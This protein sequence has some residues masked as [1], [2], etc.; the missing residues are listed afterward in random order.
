MEEIVKL[1]RI[2]PNN[3]QKKLAMHKDPQ[4]NLTIIEFLIALN[5]PL[6]IILYCLNSYLQKNIKLENESKQKYV[7]DPK[8]NEY[9]TPYETGVMEAKIIH[10]IYSYIQLNHFHNNNS[11]LNEISESWAEM[12]NILNTL[13][14]DTKIIYT[15]CWIYELL[16]L[17]L[18]KLDLNEVSDYTVKNNITEIFNTITDKLIDCAFNNKTDSINVKEG[19]L[20]L[21]YLP[22]IYLNIIET[23]FSD[24]VHYLYKISFISGQNIDEEIFSEIKN[25]SFPQTQKDKS[26]SFL[27]TQINS[28]VKN[29]YDLYYC[30]TKVYTESVYST[31]NPSSDCDFLNSNYRR[32]ACI[33]LKENYYKCLS[34]IYRDTNLLKKKLT[35]IIKLL[36]DFLKL[37]IKEENESKN[38]ENEENKDY[39]FYAEFATDFLSCLMQDCPSL[40]TSCGKSMFMDY[41]KD[42]S[43]FKATPQILR[44]W[45]KLFSL[46][47]KYYPKI[48]GKLIENIESGFSFLGGNDGEKI[49][50]IRRI[51]FIIFSCEKDE[52]LKDFDKIKKTAKMFLSE[53]K[54]K[55]SSIKLEAE[56][57]LLM[58]I[59]FLR[60]SHESV[61]KMVKD[62][63][64]IIFNELIEN[65]KN[66]SRNKNI[67]V[68]IE[69]FRFIELLSL[70]NKEEFIL[71]QWI[72]LLDTFNMKELDTKD[73]ES[74]L[75]KLIKNDNEI[76]RP[77]AVDII[78]DGDMTTTEGMIKGNQVGK[79]QL[80][81][82]TK[83]ETKE[84]FQKAAKKFFY[85][86]GDMNNYNAEINYEQIED[87]IEKD[88][89]MK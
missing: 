76:F 84:E 10:L 8:S 46:F 18:T 86:I 47:S 68:L 66:E 44:N 9:I 1:W 40:V 75:S 30:A 70:A 12:V 37:N 31:S 19:G 83:G 56:I 62:I 67:S 26:N 45:R 35:N 28:E 80:V 13:I 14:S 29:F 88:F 7:Q 57:F 81:I 82:N 22:H 5:I 21:P 43:F 33:A 65:F 42:P 89:L 54:N 59:L 73:P 11:T 61:L 34:R 74:L 64:P 25:N 16:E 58:R 27:P 78:K 79:S 63:W 72:F 4:Y 38:K 15:H 49:E 55:E 51:S 39:K 23:L 20:I 41:L 77:I 50:I 17:T 2:S 32:L 69:S 60:F 24:Q 53:Y 85:S 3:S 48:I 87:N 71:Y 52:F 36:I 6:N